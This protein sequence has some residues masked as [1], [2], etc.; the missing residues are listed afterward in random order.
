MNWS[1][2]LRWREKVHGQYHDLWKLKLVRKRLPL[3]LGYLKDGER[4]LEIGA[5]NRELEK[6]IQDR[7]PRA[8]YKSLD[9]DPTYPHDYSSF[10]EIE[11]PFDLV[12][13]FEVI[14][15]LSLEEGME[16]VAR[17]YQILNPGG[18]VILTTP[19]VYTPGQ[20]WKDATHLVAYHYEELGGLFLSQDF[21]LVEIRRIF[22]KSFIGFA[23]KGYLFSPVFRF[24][25]IDFSESILLV[26]RKS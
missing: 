5:S 2:R 13:L 22:R 9:I 19:N 15:H 20:Y 16:M 25:G 12:L 4:V 3:S 14:E 10:D 26:A 8:V 24:L 21:E 7:F 17:I 1:E 18:R 11:A 6:R 23:L